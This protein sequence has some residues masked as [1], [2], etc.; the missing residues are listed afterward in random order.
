MRKKTLTGL[1]TLLLLLGVFAAMVYAAGYSYVR[2][3]ILTIG[4]KTAYVN[5]EEIILDAAPYINAKA[6][7]TL[8]PLRF[9]EKALNAVVGWDNATR[10]ATMKTKET[11]I[12]VTIGRQTAY[13]N[14]KPVT[15]ET[16]PEIRNNRTFIPLRFVME[17][18][19]AEVEYDG[20]TKTITMLYI[21]KTG[22][23]SFT[24]TGNTLVIKYPAT[25]TVVSQDK[26][27]L[28]LKTP[29]GGVMEFKTET[30]D[31]AAVIK[32]KKD[33]HSKNGWTLTTDEPLDPA[34]P[35]N[36]TNLVAVKSDVNKPEETEVYAAYLFN[37]NQTVYSWE[38]TGK[39]FEDA[40]IFNEIWNTM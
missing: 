14:G 27:N 36:G 26:A 2:V 35:D 39:D 19:G 38:F 4:D 29:D 7:K 21:D 25:W 1:I 18:F 10:T 33:S 22:W 15:L 40:M 24:E 6:G 23:K 32:D 31:L 3:S 37:I 12:K 9:M 16:A 30:R 13:V 34:A 8:V 17:N 20:E 5:D 28:S 11:E